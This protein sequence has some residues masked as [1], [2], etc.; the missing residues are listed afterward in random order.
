[1]KDSNRIYSSEKAAHGFTLVEIMIVVVIIGLLAAIAIPA[2]QKLRT[3]SQITAFAN[4][5]RIGRDGFDSYAMENGRWPP[6]GI[7]G[8]PAEIDGYVS[9]TRFSG[10]TPLGGNWDWDN[11]QFGFTAGLSVISPTAN[12]TTMRQ[13][14][15]SIDDGN[16]ATG[17][18]RARSNGYIYVL[19]F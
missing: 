15:Q 6:D 1:M 8:L 2:F 9:D 19:E 3:K 10:P 14:D 18:F 12:V 4:D 17:N 11:G 5:L 16:L 13:L 7:S